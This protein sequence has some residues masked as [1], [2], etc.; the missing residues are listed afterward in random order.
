MKIQDYNIRDTCMLL[1]MQDKVFLGDIADLISGYYA[2]FSKTL[3]L[4]KC[5]VR[6]HDILEGYSHQL[7]KFVRIELQAARPVI[8]VKQ[9]IPFADTCFMQLDSYIIV[10]SPA[11]YA[12]F[13]Q[14]PLLAHYFD[15]CGISGNPYSKDI[16]SSHLL[17]NTD[18]PKLLLSVQHD[19]CSTMK[20]CSSHALSTINTYAC[21]FSNIVPDD[22]D[23]YAVIFNSKVFTY[24]YRYSS[25]LDQSKMPGRK[26]ALMQIPIPIRA[27]SEYVEI[28]H[29]IA[30]CQF[31]LARPNIPPVSP[32]ISNA[33][34]KKYMTDIM[35]MVV[36]EL[37]FPA[38]MRS[39][40]LSILDDNMIKAPFMLTMA[41][42]QSR[43]YE[44]YLWYQSPGNIVRQKLELLDIRSP[45]LLSP[46]NNLQM[47][48]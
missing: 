44:T 42:E 5:Q 20:D 7:G 16:I 2:K 30:D 31:Y 14:Y 19:V 32:T 15:E 48:E 21:Q 33:R 27:I 12:S 35:N 11:D 22:Y 26:Q 10:V 28:L 40:G 46:I 36:Y 8:P 25:M 24:F 18:A 34:L 29:A 43:V 6:E 37:Y 3:V 13:E 1:Q 9:I 45:E 39:K 4:S 47:N 38:Y 41:S 17:T 23:V